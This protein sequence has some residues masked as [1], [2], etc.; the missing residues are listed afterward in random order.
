[1]KI[2]VLSQYWAPENGVPQRR[3]AWLSKIL[4]NAGHEVTVVAPP[5]HYQRTVS[6]RQWL[7]HGGFFGTGNVEDGESGER[8]LRS[9]FFPA[10]TSLTGKA[11]NQIIV[12]ASMTLMQFRRLE[13]FK[14]Q[15]P[16]LVIGTVPALPTSLVTQVVAKCL[17]VPYIVDLRDA[18][19]DL[20]HESADWNTATGARSIRERVLSKGPL[21]VAVKV[22]EKLMW[23]SLAEADGI[24]TTS[25]DLATYLDTRLESVRH[26][27]RV[28]TTVRNVF[29]PKTSYTAPDKSLSKSKTLHVLYAGTV[30]RAQKLNNALEALEIARAKGYDVELRIVGDGAS[31]QALADT[32]ENLS[33]HASM[34]HRLPAKRLYEHYEWADTALVH[35]ADW[36]PLTQTIPSKTYELMS[37]GLHISA[38]VGG[39]A[40]ELIKDLEA[41]SVVPPEDPKALAALWMELIDDRSGLRVS[42]RGAEW[43]EHQRDVEVPRRLLD[44]VSTVGRRHA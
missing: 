23:R 30:G 31:W 8:I 1:M 44:I 34:A 5:P 40:A 39:E 32:A 14:G 13:A 18:W 20:L 21:Q 42:G 29:P 16:D 43:V 24:I 25:K 38:V 37:V 4:V 15:H 10:G 2:L 19:P 27:E 6:M 11:L 9:G 17:K 3:W 35:L 36:K 41:G 26:R 33:A 28:I 7:Q 12:A 22:T